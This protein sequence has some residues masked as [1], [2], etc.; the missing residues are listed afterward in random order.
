[1]WLAITIISAVILLAAILVFILEKKPEDSNVL[2]FRIR[3]IVLPIAVAL[4]TTVVLVFCFT[5]FDYKIPFKFDEDG[6]V[7]KSMVAYSYILLMVGVQYAIVFMN[8]VA[9]ITLI[10]IS[11]WITKNS[12]LV[13]DAS[14]MHFVVTNVFVIPQIILAF[15]FINSA[16]YVTT[17][18][19][20]MLP[21][22][23][24]LLTILVSFLVLI[25]LFIRGY[26]QTKKVTFK[27]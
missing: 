18:Q 3:N 1:M 11:A 23:F 20:L 4:I 9:N 8:I 21:L 2:H 5:K 24:S 6:N 13:F 27:E 14:V 16:Y 7:T 26:F 15:L 22:H 25:V 10:R 17:G 12:P 19:I